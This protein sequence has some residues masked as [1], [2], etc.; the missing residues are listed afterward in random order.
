MRDLIGWPARPTLLAVFDNH[1]EEAPYLGRAKALR[2]PDNAIVLHAKDRGCT[3]PGLHRPGLLVPKSTTSRLGRPAR[4]TTATSSPWLRTRNRAVEE[5]AWT[6]RKRKDG[7]T[8]GPTT[9]LDTG[10]ARI[11]NYPTTE[12]PHRKRHRRRGL[13]S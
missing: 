10:Q 8:N 3:R 7:R 1:T 6:T 2:H 9:H 13:S 11:N 4:T 12:Q 5:G